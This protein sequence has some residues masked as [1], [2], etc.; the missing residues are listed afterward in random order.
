VEGDTLGFDRLWSD[1]ELPIDQLTAPVREV[2][3]SRIAAALTP[4]NEE[5][6]ALIDCNPAHPAQAGECTGKIRRP[7]AIVEAFTDAPVPRHSLA[8]NPKQHE[9]RT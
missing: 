2:F 5:V 4:P 3:C 1:L 8:V 7:P 9:Q 6:A